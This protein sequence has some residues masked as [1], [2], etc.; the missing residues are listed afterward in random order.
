MMNLHQGRLLSINFVT[1][2]E[3][4]NLILSDLLR[5][6]TLE[7]PA[8]FGGQNLLNSSI[9]LVEVKFSKLSNYLVYSFEPLLC[10]CH[11]KELL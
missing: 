8:I 10:Y 2:A 7:Y 5:V 3:N 9:V 11:N 6:K 1:A 4:S